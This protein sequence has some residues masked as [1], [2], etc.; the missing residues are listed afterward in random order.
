MTADA[1]A[2]VDPDRLDTNLRSFHGRAAAAGVRVRAH[3]K[4]HR[5]VE[6]ARRQIAAGARGIAVHHAREVRR[7]AGAGIRDIVVSH[8][9][10]DPWRWELFARSAADC[11]LTLHVASPEAVAG[12]GRAAARRSTPVGVLLDLRAGPDG[13]PPAPSEVLALAR[14]VVDRP[15]LRLRGVTG[16]RGLDTAADAEARHTIGAAYATALVETAGLLRSHGLP[17]ATVCVGGTPTAAG[18]L[19]VDG[20]TEVCAGAYALQDVGLAAIGV[21]TE[22]QIALSVSGPR[23]AAELVGEYGYAW[24]AADDTARRSGNRWLPA[25]VCPVVQRVRALLPGRV[26]PDEPAEW[27]VLATGDKET[28]VLT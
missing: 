6:I 25:H 11:R 23:E 8:P 10:E 24:L 18:A 27:A 4:G 26:R 16:Y 5:T 20:I 13:S 9:W 15:W 12:L 17:C 22:E 14:A 2:Y 21:C 7:Y 1:V 3:V 19:E 28:D